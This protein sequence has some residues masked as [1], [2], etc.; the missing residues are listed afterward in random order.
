MRVK[1]YEQIKKE[2]E[3]QIKQKQKAIKDIIVSAK[4]NPKFAKLLSYSFTSLSKMITPPNSDARL[5]AKLIM[6]Q[7]GI[8]VL[9]SIA[10]KNPNNEE[11]RKQIADII[12]KL[13]SLYD[14]VD[15]ELS[16]KFVESKGHEAVMEMLSIKHKG[17][18]SVPLI[19]CLNNLCQIPQLIDK[20]LDS[21]IADTI[22]LVN[23]LYSDDPIIIRMNLDIMKRISN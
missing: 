5:N 4:N 17:A 10:Q 3:A 16:Q 19:K 22:K 21:G 12:L 11:L 7:G 6:E 8:D 18:V 13:T 2:Q 15:L 20:L 9:R 23:D 14:N 1:T